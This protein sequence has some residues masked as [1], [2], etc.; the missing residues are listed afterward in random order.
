MV[1]YYIWFEALLQRILK[2]L[3]TLRSIFQS[4]FILGQFQCALKKKYFN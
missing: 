3:R 2:K 1:I 4:A